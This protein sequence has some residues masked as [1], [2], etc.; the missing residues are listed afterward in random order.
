MIFVARF[1]YAKESQSSGF[2]SFA[3]I[4]ATLIVEDH[5]NGDQWW[6]IV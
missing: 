6:R 4:D 1:C 2:P 3:I 5:N